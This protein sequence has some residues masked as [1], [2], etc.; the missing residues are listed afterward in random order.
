MP[1]EYTVKEKADF[2]RTFDDAR[3]LDIFQYALGSPAIEVDSN[4]GS[5]LSVFCPFHGNS[6]TPAMAIYPAKGGDAGRFVCFNCDARGDIV[7]LHSMLTGLPKFQAAKDLLGTSYTPPT[8]PRQPRV[9][10]PREKTE[11]PS[12]AMSRVLAGSERY[13]EVADELLPRG[14]STETA[15]DHLLGAEDG[16]WWAARKYNIASPPRLLIPRYWEGQVYGAE[17]RRSKLTE[18]IWPTISVSTIDDIRCDIAEK[19]NRDY[20]NRAKK[21][22]KDPR[23]VGPE[24][25][26]DGAVRRAIWGPRFSSWEGSWNH[27]FNLPA[28]LRKR[29][30]DGHMLYPVV[31][32]LVITE[33]A[34]C[35]MSL[36]DVFGDDGGYLA[37]AVKAKSGINLRSMFRNVRRVYIVSDNDVPKWSDRL[38]RSISAGE[39]KALTLKGMVNGWADEAALMPATGKAEVIYVPDNESFTDANDVVRFGGANIVREWLDPYVQPVGREYLRRIQSRETLAL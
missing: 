24:D 12:F 30:E 14:I 7:T 15:N 35:T 18:T 29:P 10:K 8:I 39:R 13:S 31:S 20:F 9:A 16:E 5:Y 11:L 1:R 36:R 4:H 37:M 34:I 21:T 3:E 2:E 38:S 33:A 17:T 25:V 27:I 32:A 22:G 28:V 19:R 6:D 23:A 26:T